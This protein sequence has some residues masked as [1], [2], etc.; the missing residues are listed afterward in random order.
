M[1]TYNN[2]NELAS[3]QSA[4]PLVSDMSVFNVD[5][6]ILAKYI[7]KNVNPEVITSLK[8]LDDADIDKYP[9]ATNHELSRIF[10]VDPEVIR[11]RSIVVRH[12]IEI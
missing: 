11:Y 5:A 6:S 8:D 3:S 1:Q 2:F 7:P 10:G 12:I 9:L 4:S